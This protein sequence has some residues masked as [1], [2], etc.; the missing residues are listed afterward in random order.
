MGEA[1]EGLGNSKEPAE[2]ISLASNTT[3]HF[4]RNDEDGKM[5][6][7]VRDKHTGEELY[8]IP[9]DFLQDLNPEPENNQLDVRI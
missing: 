5:Y 9:K 6:M 4:E 7:H 8:R 3:I 1:R 2:N